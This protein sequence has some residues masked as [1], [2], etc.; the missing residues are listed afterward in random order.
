MRHCTIEVTWPDLALAFALVLM[1]V[2]ISR[3]QRLGL[4]RGFL[5]GAVRAVVQLVAVGYVLVYLF[6]ADRSW[7]VLLTLAVMLLSATA[8]AAR[9]RRGPSG[10]PVAGA[11]RTL[12]GISGTTMLLGSGLTLADVTY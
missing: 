9:R 7:L 3:W 2:A 6:T 4:E 11:R 12:W 10:R 8:A 1:A 5:V